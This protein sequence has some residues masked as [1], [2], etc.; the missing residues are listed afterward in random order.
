MIY[1]LTGIISTKG[2]SELK[3]GFQ[4]NSPSIYVS[5][6]LEKSNLDYKKLIEAVKKMPNFSIVTYDKGGSIILKKNISVF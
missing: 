6:Y 5:I 4:F 3:Y 2:F 1:Y